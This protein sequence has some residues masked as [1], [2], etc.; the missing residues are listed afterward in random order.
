MPPAVLEERAKA[1]DHH[2]DS[3]IR[4]VGVGFDQPIIR[5]GQG[6]DIDIK[7][8]KVAGDPL[9][10]LLDEGEF[11]SAEGGNIAIII[12]GREIKRSHHGYIIPGRTCRGVAVEVQVDGGAS[13]WVR[14]QPE[15]IGKGYQR[16][17]S[18][19]ANSTGDGSLCFQ[20]INLQRQLRADTTEMV[21]VVLQPLV[22]VKVLLLGPILDEPWG[23]FLL[24]GRSQEPF[25][26]RQ[27]GFRPDRLGRDLATGSPGSS[28]R[29]A[30]C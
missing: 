29:G 21:M 30:R 12:I 7:G 15:G 2:P 17:P 26:L 4:I 22:G 25:D 24:P 27:K 19:D 18:A 1:G 9:P 5:G 10:G 20:H 23:R 11:A 13:R 14:A 6:S 28:S 16:C 3:V 8:S